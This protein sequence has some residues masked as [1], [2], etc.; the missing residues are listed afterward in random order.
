MDQ[1]EEKL[2]RFMPEVQAVELKCME[3]GSKGTHEVA[4]AHLP[5]EIKQLIKPLKSK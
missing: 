1:K 4:F 2:M 5:K 3:P